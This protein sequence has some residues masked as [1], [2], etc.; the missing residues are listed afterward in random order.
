M[1]NAAS[2]PKPSPEL[3][4]RAEA[5]LRESRPEAASRPVAD[6]RLVHE[7][8]VHQVELEMQNEE[9]RRTQSELAQT[10]ERYSELYDFAPA[11]YLTLDGK[12][13]IL[14]ANLAAARMLRVPRGR[15]IGMP[16]PRFI[17][18]ESQDAFYLH[19]RGLLSG[20]T[21]AGC[22]LALRAP[23]GSE[24]FVHLESNRVGESETDAPSCRT[25]LV[26]ITARRHAERALAAAEGELKETNGELRRTNENL[27]SRVAERTVQ[28]R[29]L[30]AQLTSLEEHERQR[31]SDNLHEGL[32]QLLSGAL[33]NLAALAPHLREPTATT[34]YENVRG[35]LLEAIRAGRHLTEQLSPPVLRALGLS[36]AL[37]SLGETCS[38]KHRLEV[39]AQIAPDLPI[40][41]TDL[42]IALFRAAEELLRNVRQHADVS[43]ATLR[44]QKLAGGMVRL[45]VSDAGR[46]FDP[47]AVRA[48]E[49]KLGGFGLFR[50]RERIE[51]LGGHVVI[52]TAPGRGTRVRIQ[53]RTGTAPKQR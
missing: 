11:G 1:A 48:R 36:A 19:R 3:R 43:R 6:D 40:P 7:L 16:F 52:R 37:E 49:G 46:G 51:S 10:C 8:Q 18:R 5:A 34:S 31:A 29:E 39:E 41:G 32:L 47:A 53:V 24:L 23:G 30:T 14:E 27:E 17:A 44:L 21:A 42:T 25:V 35:C 28:L 15:L 45:E 20:D 33:M 38:V 9:L 50:V 13:V 4:D 26:D 12:G 2:R 22:E